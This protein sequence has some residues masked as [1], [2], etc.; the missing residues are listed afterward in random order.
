MKFRPLDME[1]L[2]ARTGMEIE[3]HVYR[4]SMLKPR[5]K[6]YFFFYGLSLKFFFILF[7]LVY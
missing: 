6:K 1:E 2:L 5:E 3:S 4:Y 7:S